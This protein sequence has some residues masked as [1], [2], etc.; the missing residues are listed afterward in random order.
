MSTLIEQIVFAGQLPQYTVSEADD[1]A[2]LSRLSKINIFVG[3]N[4][5]GKSRFM[6][7]LVNWQRQFPTVPH[8]DLTKFGPGLY[9]IDREFQAHN[10]E[11]RQAIQ[12]RGFR[13][14]DGILA[15]M[16][17]VINLRNAHQNWVPSFYALMLRAASANKATNFQDA[18]KKQHDADV[19]RGI[20]QNLGNH[21]ANTIRSHIKDYKEPREIKPVYFPALRTLRPLGDGDIIA[22]RTRGDY[23]KDRGPDIFTGHT[24]YED[25]QNFLL[26]TLT[27][28]QMI[29][30]F[31]EFLSRQFFDAQ[32]VALIPRLSVTKKTFITRSWSMAEPTLLIGRFWIRSPTP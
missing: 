19:V 23:F 9:Q 13:D 11:L 24:I 32:P 29:K 21:I 5:S 2:I 8:L 28:R 25:V 27:Q 3:A 31:Q 30:E 10:N 1:P 12:Q 22:A 17:N 6:R 20:L 16:D 26:G 15:S 7:E 4:N 14:V 18:A